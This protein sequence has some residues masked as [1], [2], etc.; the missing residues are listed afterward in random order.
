[1]AWFRAMQRCTLHGCLQGHGVVVSLVVT[2]VARTRVVSVSHKRTSEQVDKARIATLYGQRVARDALL[3]QGPVCHA[4]G[5]VDGG[6]GVDALGCGCEHLPG[7][8]WGVRQQ[9][10]IVY[11]C[12]CHY[13]CIVLWGVRHCTRS[14]MIIRSEFSSESR[15]PVVQY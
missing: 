9:H 11:Q 1:M 10:A 5:G 3:V 15:C 8:C 13:D 14:L 12:C 7:T 6:G 2:T 4:V